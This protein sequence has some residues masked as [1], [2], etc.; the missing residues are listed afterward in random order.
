MTVLIANR[1]ILD[2]GG[3][4]PIATAWWNGTN[5]HE[6]AVGLWAYG[7]TGLTFGFQVASADIGQ[8]TAVEVLTDASAIGATDGNASNDFLSIPFFVGTLPTANLTWEEGRSTGEEVLIDASGSF[9]E[10]GGDVRCVFTVVNSLEPRQGSRKTTAPSH[11]R[12][13]TAARGASPSTSSTKRATLAS[14]RVKW[15]CSTAHQKWSLK[16]RLRWPHG[17]RPPSVSWRPTTTTRSHRPD[18]TCCS[19]GPA[20]CVRKEA[21]RPLHL[22]PPTR[23]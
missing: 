20:S 6:V 3:S 13:T 21:H 12:G 8:P 2:V 14:P 4:N 18:L 23:A 22:L 15:S 11:G 5:L 10:D 17:P 19:R 7:Q 9:D 1:G 16:P